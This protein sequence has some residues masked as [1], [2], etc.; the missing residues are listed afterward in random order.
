MIFQISSEDSAS[1]EVNKV[2]NNILA[3]NG[4]Y[5]NL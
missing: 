5:K 2:S 3:T 4:K 1:T